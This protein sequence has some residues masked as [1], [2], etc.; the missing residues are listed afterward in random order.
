VAN[1]DNN[2]RS[3][4]NYL[5][6]VAVGFLTAVAIMGGILFILKNTHEKEENISSSVELFI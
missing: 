2:E 1:E 4:K 5:V 3:M 6:A